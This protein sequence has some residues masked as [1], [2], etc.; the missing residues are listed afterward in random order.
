MLVGT[1][2]GIIGDTYDP[3]FDPDFFKVW[4]DVMLQPR[5]IGPAENP[6][7]IRIQNPAHPML[8]A[9]TP[10]AARFETGVL[11]AVRGPAPDNDTPTSAERAAQNNTPGIP[12]LAETASLELPEGVHLVY[13]VVFGFFSINGARYKFDDFTF[14]APTTDTTIDIT[15]VERINQPP[16]RS[17]ETVLRMLPDDWDITEDGRMRLYANGIELGVSK[18]LPGALWGVNIV[19]QPPVIAAGDNRVGARS[20]IGVAAS[21]VV[22]AAGD[23]A[24]SKRVRVVLD[25]DGDIDDIVIEEE[26]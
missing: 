20:A 17:Q 1:A 21:E 18:P 9:L 7:Q 22:D 8:V 4:C 2:R 12:L 10:M 19:D 25:S 15:R 26:D 13:D 24:P 3:G 16:S 14:A 11:R 23:L 6:Y 5:L